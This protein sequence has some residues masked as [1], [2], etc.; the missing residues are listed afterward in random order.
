MLE[1][2]RLAVMADA[3]LEAG[4]HPAEVEKVKLII[5]R[6]FAVVDMSQ[7]DAA[8]TPAIFYAQSGVESYDTCTLRER[9][10]LNALKAHWQE[11]LEPWRRQYLG[12][13][14]K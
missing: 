4:Y 13:W 11:R 7:L 8:F 3:M 1:S 9:T 10:L 14:L 2:E 5:T 6:H 12:E